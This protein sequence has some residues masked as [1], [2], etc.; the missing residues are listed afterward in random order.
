[1]WSEIVPM[2]TGRDSTSHTLLLATTICG[3]VE[4]LHEQIF[5]DLGTFYAGKALVEALVFEG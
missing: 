1:M 5:C 3:L 4:S 2:K